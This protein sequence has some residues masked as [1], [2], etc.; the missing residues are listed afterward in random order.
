MYRA[1]LG[2]AAEASEV[3]EQIGDKFDAIVDWGQ[4]KG[5]KASTIIDVTCNPPVI[6][7]E[8]AISKETIKEYMQAV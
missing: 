6:L 8:G 7:R 5:G 2:L 3:A 4:T 1:R